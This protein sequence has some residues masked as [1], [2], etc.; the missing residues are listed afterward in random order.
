M[1]KYK[2]WEGWPIDFLTKWTPIKVL[3]VPHCHLST[4]RG[5]LQK[6]TL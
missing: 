5:H 2:N 3:V 6:E 4:D 1:E